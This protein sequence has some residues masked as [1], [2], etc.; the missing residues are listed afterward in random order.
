MEKD[1]KSPFDLT[2]KTALI[3]GGSRGLGKEMARI[4]ALHGA[5]I[6][7]ASRNGAELSAALVEILSGTSAKGTAIVADLRSR[8]DVARLAHEALAFTGRVDILVNN[9]GSNTPQPVSDITDAVYDEI[10]QVS[11]HAPMSLTRALA[12]GMKER[13]WGRII[14]ISSIM[15]EA[16]LAGRTAYAATRAAALGQ[17]RAWAQDLGSFGI[18]VNAIMPGPFLTELPARVTTPEQKELFSTHTILKRWGNPSEI[19]G[20]V[21]LLASDAGSYITGTVL[22]V[23]GGYLSA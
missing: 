23:D 12:P 10:V 21:L 4:F 5:S 7:I 14:N 22:R 13:G 20:P 1:M 11:Q 19:A 15:A 18:T 6:I 16:P 8:E 9:A 3:T 2:G 17:T